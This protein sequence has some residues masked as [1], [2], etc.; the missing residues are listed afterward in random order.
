[1]ETKKINVFGVNLDRLNRRELNERVKKFLNDGRQHQITTPNPEFLLNAHRDEEYFFILNSADLSVP[2]GIGL[3]FAAWATGKNL[4]RLAGADLVYDICAIAQNE[5]KS[6]FLLGGGDGVSLET[7]KNLI[8]KYPKL[9]IVG[10]D[11]GL[12]AGEWEL[13]SG[14]WLRGKEKN[15]RL[16]EAIRAKNP[17]I[18]FVAF[19][20]GTRQEKW[21]YH[22]LKSLPSVKLAIGVGGTFDYISGKIKRAP[23]I[24]RVIGLE[25]LWR[26][27]LEPIRMKRIIN[28]VIV[29]PWEFIKWR[30]ILPFFYRSNI[31][32][33]VFKK[34]NGKYKILLL[35]RSDQENHWQLPQGGTDGESLVRAGTR[36]LG[37]EIGTDKFKPIKVFKNL[38]KYKFD[39]RALSKF[40]V[41][42]RLAS[43]YKGQKQSLLIA[44][45]TG[46]DSDI[47]VN[48]W[49]HSG[50]KWIG[51]E[52]LPGEVHHY[53][54]EAAKIY[55]EKFNG[56]KLKDL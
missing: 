46:Q 25:W 55:L 43:G 18:L 17:D 20:G 7:E 44:E 45:F 10:A 27:I 40:K 5:N 3:K 22:N 52:N 31:A 35:K 13:K 50:W 4:F 21:I 42:S 32:C 54:K 30:F 23:K 33:L 56:L 16:L 14:A 39:S 37:E 38:W 36:E 34:E 19:G 11:E 1:M 51:S 26:L 29:F 47:N 2:D 6:I 53:R 8:K 48:F 12:K 41:T 28:A 9:N 15:D 24:M 49:E